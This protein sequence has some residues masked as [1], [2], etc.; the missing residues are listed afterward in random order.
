MPDVREYGRGEIGPR[1]TP[2]WRSIGACRGLDP[3]IFF[4]ED[5]AGER[6]AKD[7]C[8]G[9]VVRLACLEYALATREKHGVWGGATESERRSMIRRSRRGI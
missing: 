1:P 5:D 9:C 8:A 7:V 3:E 4:P 2:N 6:A